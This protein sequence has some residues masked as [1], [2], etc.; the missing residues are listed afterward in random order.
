[1]LISPTRANLTVMPG[2]PTYCYI[3][4]PILTIYTTQEP[5]GSKS[6]LYIPLQLYLVST[7]F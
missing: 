1:M 3:L 7:R 2:G 5:I 4:L 6:K